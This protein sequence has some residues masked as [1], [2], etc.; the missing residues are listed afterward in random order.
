MSHVLHA[1]S[2]ALVI[3]NL[4]ILVFG[5]IIGRR[6]MPTIVTLKEVLCHDCIFRACKTQGKA[7]LDAVEG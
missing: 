6:I 3:S 2:R 4:G 1:I 7:C 5:I